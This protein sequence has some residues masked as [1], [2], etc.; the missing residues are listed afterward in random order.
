MLSKN[1]VPPRIYNDKDNKKDVFNDNDKDVF[2][3]NDKVES[4]K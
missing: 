1:N 3:D 4:P 2:N